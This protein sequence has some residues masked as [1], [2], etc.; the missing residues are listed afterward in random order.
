MQRYILT[1]KAL[2]QP[3]LWRKQVGPLVYGRLPAVPMDAGTTLPAD[4][5]PGRYRFW[6]LGDWIPSRRAREVY[7]VTPAG[8]VTYAAD[9]LNFHAWR[10][11]TPIYDADWCEPY[12]ERDLEEFSE[13]SVFEVARLYPRW[14]AEEARFRVKEAVLMLRQGRGPFMRVARQHVRFEQATGIRERQAP[15]P[16]IRRLMDAYDAAQA[17]LSAYLDAGGK[18][19]ADSI[20]TY[21]STIFREHGIDDTTIKVT[22]QHPHPHKDSAPLPWHLWPS[23]ATWPMPSPYEITKD[24]LTLGYDR[25]ALDRA[26]RSMGFPPLEPGAPRYNEPYT[27]PLSADDL[28]N[29]LQPGGDGVRITADPEPRIPPSMAEIVYRMKP[30]HGALPHPAPDTGDEEPSAAGWTCDTCGTYHEAGYCPGPIG[31]ESD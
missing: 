14:L 7:P 4:L 22:E 10:F 1:R 6:L 17:G 5:W 24:D 26:L 2:R 19:D 11:V 23:M 8:L 21:L 3:N 16:P 12:Q 9:R 13:Y 28:L 29:G 15:P 31:S 25:E 18:I 27:L 20:A 30:I